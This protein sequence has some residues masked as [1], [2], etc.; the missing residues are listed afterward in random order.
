MTAPPEADRGAGPPTPKGAARRAVIVDAA[1][2]VLLA[3]G[4]AGTTHRAVASRAGV[5]LGSTT[6][7]FADRTELVREALEG[8]ADREAQ[9]MAAVVARPW[10][11]GP[12]GRGQLASRLVDVVV[13]AERLASPGEVAAAYE[14]F[15]EA[16]RSPALGSPARRW[17]RDTEDAV[18]AL[19]VGTPY[20]S[21]GAPTVLALVDGAVVA[22]L[23]AEGAV[24]VDLVAAVEGHLRALGPARRRRRG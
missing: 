15:L 6:Y 9:R 1:V 24:A 18:T 22:W 4:P 21:L 19:L 11:R 8:L 20:A 23:V 3:E 12:H 13:G 14:R 7:Y 10:P 17:Q 2:D 5:P 16:A